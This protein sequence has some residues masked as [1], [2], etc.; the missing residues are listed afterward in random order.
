MSHFAKVENGIVTQVLVV[1]NEHEHD[2]QKYLNSIG[3]EGTWVQC[4]YNGNIRKM[5]PGIGYEYWAEKDAFRQ[6]RPFPSW[7]F[8]SKKWAWKA[9][10]PYPT[11]GKHYDWNEKLGDWVEHNPEAS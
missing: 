11:D 3:L 1:A 2:G 7:S 5:F 6:P 10:K 8:D 9:P 4:S